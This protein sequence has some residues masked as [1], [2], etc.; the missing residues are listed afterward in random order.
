MQRKSWASAKCPMARFVDV[1]GDWG[2]LLGLVKRL[3]V[4]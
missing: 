2:S 1:I 3:A 4:R